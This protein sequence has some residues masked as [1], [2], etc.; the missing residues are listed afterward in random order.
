MSMSSLLLSKKQ[1]M[2]FTEALQYALNPKQEMYHALGAVLVSSGDVISGGSNEPRSRFTP[3]KEFMLE[4]DKSE[5]KLYH[6]MISNKSI[7]CASIHAEV[8]AL[9]NLETKQGVL[10]ELQKSITLHS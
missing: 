6:Q 9:L 5:R 2:Y 8:S 4:M 3:P 10:P 1:E 7:N